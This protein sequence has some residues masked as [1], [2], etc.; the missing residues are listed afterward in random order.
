MNISPL[1]SIKIYFSN[2]HIRST[3]ALKQEGGYCIVNSSELGDTPRI[4]T[5]Y[6][7]CKLRDYNALASISIMKPFHSLLV[8]SL[9]ACFSSFFPPFFTINS[10]NIM[11]NS[12]Q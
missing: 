1:T 8:Y 11:V 4:D 6:F 12:R 3:I 9:P 10:L 2:C 5:A 7:L